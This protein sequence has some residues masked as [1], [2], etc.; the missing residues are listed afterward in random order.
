MSI[1]PSI[2]VFS[3]PYIEDEDMEKLGVA[4]PGPCFPSLHGTEDQ[5]TLDGSFCKQ[6]FHL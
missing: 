5:V 1:N 3:S 4:A 6:S 2:I